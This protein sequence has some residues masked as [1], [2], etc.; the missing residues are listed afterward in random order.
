M[1]IDPRSWW[2]NR[3]FAASSG[4]YLV[5]GDVVPRR[6]LELEPWDTARRDLLVLLLRDLT[7]RRIEGDMAELGVYKGGT[8]R[9]LHHYAPERKLY[10][11]NTFAGSDRRDVRAERASTGRETSERDFSDTYV[12]LVLRNIAPQN[13][14][15]QVYPGFFPESAPESVRNRRFAFVH[16]DADLY[17]P[18][19][20][21]LEYFYPRTNRGEFLV[22]RDFHSWPGARKAV[23]EFFQD[24][25]ETPVPTSDKSGSVVIVKL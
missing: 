15:V 13:D 10:L 18:I 16:L 4:G 1:D 6:V 8:A 20:A 2:H 7:E 11:F 17:E 22:V 14:N 24:K 9:L 12:G 3:E 25:P 21:G 23:R 5:P 19:L